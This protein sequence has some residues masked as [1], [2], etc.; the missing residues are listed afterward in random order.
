MEFIIGGVIG[1]LLGTKLA[2][3]LSTT[4]DALNRVFAG[5]VFVTAIYMLYNNAAAFGVHL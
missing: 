5:F 4:K 3:S 2:T 1:G